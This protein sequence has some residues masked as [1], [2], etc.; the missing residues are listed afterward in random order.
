MAKLNSFRLWLSK[1][2]AWEYLP[3][4]VATIP[5]VGFWLWFALRARSLFF[6]SN[7]NPAIP[8]GGAIGESKSDILK[9][10]PPEISSKWVLVKPDESFDQV[11]EA[12]KLAG[13][14]F[15]IIAK[16]D[17]GERGFLVKKVD[18]EA[19]LKTYL[20]KWQAPFILQEFLSEPM[21]A[22]VLF[23]HY[24]GESGKFGITSICLQ[25]FLKVK[26]DGQSSVRE[27]MVKDT[28]SAFQLERFER[29]FPDVLG[30]IP[31]NGEEIILELIGNHSRGTK[32]LNGN[33]LIE[34]K[35]T[36]SFR[37]I[38]QKIEGVYYGR[39][40]LKFQDFEA[41]KNGRF[42]TMELNGIL[43]EP[44]HIYD[45]SHGIWRAYRDQFK[46]WKL[47][48]KLHKAQRQLGIKPASFREGYGIAR[49]YYRYMGAL[50]KV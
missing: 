37:R 41:L 27:L 49:G 42:K 32:F 24:P 7:V 34:P 15:P 25:D 18:D 10:L 48:F 2:T 36:E 23:H 5:I 43:A 47:L 44:A 8:L 26:G 21:E 22:A 17:I 28:R 46:H 39:F 19:T 3:W 9:L 20:A 35:L 45:P 16:P 14:E 30:Q 1:W 50:N 11:K 12:M 4:S 6:F 40:D 38:C 33:Y 31:K 13:L 29:D